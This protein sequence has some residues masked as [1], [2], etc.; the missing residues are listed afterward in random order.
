MKTACV[1]RWGAFGDCIQ[2]TPI[3]SLLK[4]DG[5]KVLFH[6]KSKG[7]EVVRNNPNIDKVVIQ[8]DNAIG[9]YTV[10]EFW[11]LIG[12]NFDRF[13]NL[14]GSIEER[15]LIPGKPGWKEL[16]WDKDRRH[17]YC[18]LNY[19]DYMMEVAGYPEETGKTGELYFSRLEEAWA[20]KW[21]KKHQGKFIVLWAISG[22]A[23][24]KVYPYT[25]WVVSYLAEHHRDMMIVFVGGP[26]CQIMEVG[27]EN[28]PRIKAY[29]GKM[30]IRKTMLLTKY[31]DLVVGPETG[32]MNAA[33]CYDTPKIVFL[34]HST[35][36]NLTKHWTNCISI[37]PKIDCYPCH[38]LHYSMKYCNQ[39]HK[40][41]GAMCMAMLHPKNVIKEIEGVYHGNVDQ[42]RTSN[43]L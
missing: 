39:D 41:G 43:F 24:H 32:V 11:D 36:E 31:A 2:T 15:L 23:L 30:P 37:E 33:A 17:E 4:K 10:E 9:A 19:S 12:S 8:P 5:Y 14:S 3:F 35:K 40:T 25:E 26:E 34:S 6:T 21:R 13:I 27:L 28:H 18:N 7:A 29:S 20:K 22:S 38:I 42:A 1:L 16:D